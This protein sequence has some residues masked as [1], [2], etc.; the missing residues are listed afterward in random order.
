MWMI[1]LLLIAATFARAPDAVKVYAVERF[2]ES[3]YQ[4]EY[5]VQLSLQ[6]NPAIAGAEAFL[7]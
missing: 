6:H 4:L 5:I 1:Y 7:N 3:V 2:P